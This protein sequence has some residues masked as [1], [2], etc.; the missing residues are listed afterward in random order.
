M[1][2]L[3]SNI[4][5]LKGNGFKMLIDNSQFANVEYFLTAFSFPGL[6]ATGISLP[7]RGNNQFFDGEAIEVDVITTTFI[8]SENLENYFEIYNWMLRNQNKGGEKYDITIAILNSHNNVVAKFRMANAFPVNL[9]SFELS[10]QSTEEIT[11]TA[12]FQID[13]FRKIEN[14]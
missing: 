10:T 1:N 5:P 11:T 6:S 14:D 4:N 9:A 8:V 12:S 3:T 7:F 13:Y 2:N